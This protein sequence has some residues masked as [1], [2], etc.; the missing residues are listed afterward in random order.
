MARICAGN[1]KQHTA[2]RCSNA[3][4]EFPFVLQRVTP[5]PLGRVNALQ[6]AFVIGTNQ[7]AFNASPAFP[8]PPAQSPRQTAASARL[9]S[10]E[11]RSYWMDQIPPII[12]SLD[13]SVPG[14][15]ND[16]RS[17]FLV[18]GVTSYGFGYCLAACR[19]R[20]GANRHQRAYRR[21]ITVRY[22]VFLTREAGNS[23]RFSLPR[24]LGDSITGPLRF[25]SCK[26]SCIRWL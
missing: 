7:R 5:P 23:R 22:T 6:R 9:S 3:L 24:Q 25:G 1:R 18:N 4:I 20:P 16:F 21:P 10:A 8:E 14:I 12:T 17:M 11:F 19:C 15:F 26:M 13:S 2:T